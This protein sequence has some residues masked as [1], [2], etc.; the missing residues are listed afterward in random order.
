MRSRVPKGYCRCSIRTS[1]P[2]DLVPST[3]I[4]EPCQF[5]V[6]SFNLRG[7]LV[8]RI[9]ELILQK[10]ENALGKVET[11]KS[12]C[13]G[14]YPA[15]PLC[16]PEAAPAKPLSSIKSPCF[17]FLGRWIWAN[18]GSHLL[19]LANWNQSFYPSTSTDVSEFGLLGIGHTNL[20]LRSLVS[21]AV[22]RIVLPALAKGNRM[23]SIYAIYIAQGNVYNYNTEKSNR[24]R[25]KYKRR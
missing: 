24:Y 25:V 16:F 3:D 4:D 19:V 13:P 15:W 14:A 20:R 17:L 8:S 2:F 9:C 18:P 6:F 11:Q 5:A 12:D 23:L 21:D 10:Q 7:G 22:N 1:L